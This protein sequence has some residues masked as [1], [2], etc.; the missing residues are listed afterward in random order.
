[1]E[2]LKV[3]ALSTI[4]TFKEFLEIGCKGRLVCRNTMGVET[5]MHVWRR[6]WR[7]RVLER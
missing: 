6:G 4:L 7:H 5:S 1:M 2:D 3:W